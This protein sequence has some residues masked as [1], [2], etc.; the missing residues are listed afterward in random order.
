MKYVHQ[1]WLVEQVLLGLFSLSAS[2]WLILAD[3]TWNIIY[4]VCMFQPNTLKLEINS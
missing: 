2:Y 1:S 3:N 4:Y